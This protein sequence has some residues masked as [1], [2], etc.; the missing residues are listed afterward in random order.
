VDRAGKKQAAEFRHPGAQLV[1]SAR[2]A[3]I[4]T[5]PPPVWKEG[6]FSAIFTKAVIAQGPALGL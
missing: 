1:C 5:A 2:T 3:H 6:R 4:A